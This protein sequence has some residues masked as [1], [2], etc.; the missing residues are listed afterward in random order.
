MQ[1]LSTED[2]NK[3]TPLPLRVSF[4]CKCEPERVRFKYKIELDHSR[5]REKTK[6]K[7]LGTGATSSGQLLDSSALVYNA[8]T[9]IIQ[10][11]FQSIFL[12][13]MTTKLEKQ[14]QPFQQALLFRLL[15][16]CK[17]MQ[18]TDQLREVD[19]K[20]LASMAT[21][22][23][24][25]VFKIEESVAFLENY[26]R[27]NNIQA[28]KDNVHSA[29]GDILK[30]IRVV[31]ELNDTLKGLDSVH[32]WLPLDYSLNEDKSIKFDNM[33]IKR[34]SGGYDIVPSGE[35]EPLASA[36]LTQSQ[37]IGLRPTPNQWRQIAYERCMG[38][39]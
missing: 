21:L 32:L 25:G 38:L 11:S 14:N 23:N 9:K 1:E 19:V 20:K 33:W 5:V 30:F 27:T 35:L 2:I 37:N 28:T 29:F 31:T 10:M 12:Q 4:T 24:P 39:R 15:S 8:T 13:R 6:Y 22:K 36:K 34:P 3:L 7:Y 17:D 18:L 26:L 16:K